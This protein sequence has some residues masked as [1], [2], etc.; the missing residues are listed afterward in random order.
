MT[1]DRESPGRTE[2]APGARPDERL[3]LPSLSVQGLRGIEDLSIPRLGRV[4]LLA[5]RNGVGKTTVLDA[6]R[7][8]ASRAR[9]AVLSALLVGREEIAA[10]KDEDGGRMSL[11]D[12]RALFFGRDTSGDARIAIGPL[13][14]PDQLQIRVASLSGEPDSLS[15]TLLG[16]LKGGDTR[17]M[18]ISFRDSVQL[19]P[20]GPQLFPRELMQLLA[21]E[22]SELPPE[23]SCES[24]GPGLPGSG[25]LARLWDRI[26][27]TDDEDRVIRAVNLAMDEAAERV[28][29][30]GDSGGHGRQGPNGRRVV[31]RIEDQSHPVPLKSLG[32]GAVRLLGVALA[33]AN[34]RDGFLLIDEAENGIH[35]AVQ[36]D[37]W[38]MVLQ[39]ARDNNVQVL[40]TTHGW[41]CVRGF[42]QAATELAAVEGVLVRLERRA[43]RVRAIEYTENE[44]AVAARDGVEVR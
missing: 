38:R 6:V 10:G 29:V 36:R 4:T 8:H 41:D 35:H 18:K 24:L 44:L 33:L 12:G 7:I 32:D 17:V 34:S 31:V 37:F 19:L 3:H 28:A 1:S 26:T 25:E 21:S 43:D 16:K 42:A 14:G 39:T 30:V 2:A 20:P 11:S 5:G 15:K 27:L 23:V 22:A 40:A 13:D 9:P